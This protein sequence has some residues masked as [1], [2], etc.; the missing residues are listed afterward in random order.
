M[1]FAFKKKKFRAAH[2]FREEEKNF[3]GKKTKPGIVHKHEFGGNFAEFN[4]FEVD[5]VHVCE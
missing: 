3:H 4:P 2:S 5:T 1:N